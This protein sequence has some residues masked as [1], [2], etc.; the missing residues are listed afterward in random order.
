MNTPPPEMIE[1]WGYKDQSRSVASYMK[2]LFS[3][4]VQCFETK[5]MV[6][7]YCLPSSP[8]SP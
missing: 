8:I 1:R 4:A 6:V 2:L 3:S 7:C 5:L